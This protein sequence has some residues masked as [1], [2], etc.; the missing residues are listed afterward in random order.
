MHRLT[1]NRTSYHDFNPCREL[2]LSEV[3]AGLR[4]PQKELPSKYF[5]NQQGSR[6]FEQICTLDEYYI[7]K[8]EDSIMR[9]YIN[10]IVELTGSQALLIE[11]GSGNCEKVRLLLDHLSD[12]AAFIAVDISRKQL[13]QVTKQ[14]ALSYP[15]LEVI[16]FCADY[17]RN[18]RI[19]LPK[20]KIKRKLVYFPGSTIGNF[21]PISA[22]NFL[23]RIGKVCRSSGILLIG[24]DL[25]KD[26][27]VFSKAYNDKEGITAAFNLN[28]L[29][30]IN[31]ELKCDFKLNNFRHYA[32]YNLKENRVEM[33]LISQKNQVIH[34]NGEVIS[35][36]KGESIWTESSYKFSLDEFEQLARSANFKVERTWTDNRK[37]FSVQFLV[38]T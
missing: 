20:K 29:S 34:L 27:T 23:H 15:R 26:V 3:L 32:F 22:K 31:Q 10:E 28:L 12:P 21:D 6:L 8:I 16:P 30:R 7:P 5:Y 1:G 18:F 9:T 14:L 4:K 25:K 36:V 24:V 2:F 38:R 17:T 35:F 19:P 37:W 13:L 11:Y 33:H